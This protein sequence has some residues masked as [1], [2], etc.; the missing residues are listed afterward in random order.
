MTPARVRFT[1]NKWTTSIPQAGLLAIGAQS[2]S[3]TVMG[4]C[5]LL[6]AAV[7]LLAW[8]QLFRAAELQP[9]AERVGWESNL[10]LE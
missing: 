6:A 8:L 4:I 1:W 9:R 10:L 3:R 5:L 7:S 2:E